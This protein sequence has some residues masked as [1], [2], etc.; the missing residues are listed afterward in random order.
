MLLMIYINNVIIN[1]V[2]ISSSNSTDI[3]SSNNNKNSFDDVFEKI[4]FNENT[5]NNLKPI[6]NNTAT[7]Y[8]QTITN[9]WLLLKDK[10]I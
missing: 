2:I 8:N 6:K 5:F 7:S 4:S 1:E 9:N 10:G 3:V